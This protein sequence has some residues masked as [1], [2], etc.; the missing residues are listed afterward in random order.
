MNPIQ[1]SNIAT[2]LVPSITF[3]S[4]IEGDMFWFQL[5]NLLKNKRN[6]DCIGAFMHASR[7]IAPYS[8]VHLYIFIQIITSK[9]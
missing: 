4:K 3:T 8:F 2:K 7:L 5:K 1:V 6:I 9:P